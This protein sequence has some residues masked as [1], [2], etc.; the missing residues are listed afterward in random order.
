MEARCAREDRHGLF[1]RRTPVFARADQQAKRR[2]ARRVAGRMSGGATARFAG[3]TNWRGGGAPLGDGRQV[4]SDQT[5]RNQLPLPASF[6][7]TR[8]D[9]G[10]GKRGE[11]PGRRKT[12]NSRAASTGRC[13]RRPINLPSRKTRARPRVRPDPLA[14]TVAADSRRGADIRGPRESAGSS[15]AASRRRRSG[16]RRL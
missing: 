11:F 9:W 7:L 8:N 3:A 1:R 5:S 2:R 6:W 4:L 16:G 13:K 14:P 12:W 10:G 15:G